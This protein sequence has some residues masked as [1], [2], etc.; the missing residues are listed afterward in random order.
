MA[1]MFGCFCCCSTVT[2]INRSFS[3]NQL[4]LS[5][6]ING[7]EFPILFINHKRFT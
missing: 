3:M 4:R 2:E 6:Q 1:I 7:E 5:W